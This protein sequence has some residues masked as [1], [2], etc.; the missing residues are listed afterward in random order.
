MLP[1]AYLELRPM[2]VQAH[3][4][5]EIVYAIGGTFGEWQFAWKE[6]NTCDTVPQPQ[7]VYIDICAER[8]FELS[9]HL[10]ALWCIIFEEPSTTIS[11][12]T[13]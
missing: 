3:G 11:T 13:S 9:A 1:L 6:P 5:S 4:M 10:P 7:E 8:S 2:L 12:R